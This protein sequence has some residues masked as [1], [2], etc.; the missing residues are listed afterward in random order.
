MKIFLI[1]DNMDTLTGLR[2]A[3]IDGVIAKSRDEASEAFRTAVL[4]KE[5]GIILITE[6]LSELISEEI[7]NI[8]LDKALP[9]VT[10]VPDGSE[11]KLGKS[12]ITDYIKESI[13]L[14]I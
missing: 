14:K 6:R 12:F 2:L 13:G 8:K 4:F 5:N 9:V 3:G 11:S 7:K 10:I 1:S